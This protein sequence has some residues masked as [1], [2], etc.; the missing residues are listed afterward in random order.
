MNTE[1]L[2]QYPEFLQYIVKHYL[3]RPF[4]DIIFF[5]PDTAALTQVYAATATE[6]REKKISGKYFVPVG[7]LC[8]TSYHAKNMTL[9]S[10]SKYFLQE[11]I[12][13]PAFAKGLWE[14]SETLLKER[15]FL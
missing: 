11:F 9:Q 1:L 8:D 15:G 4:P 14:F 5:E 6:I 7:E 13:K 2:R 10:V 3:F 12:M